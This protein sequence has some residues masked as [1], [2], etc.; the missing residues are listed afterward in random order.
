MALLKPPHRGGK[1]ASLRRKSKCPEQNGCSSSVVEDSFEGAY[2]GEFGQRKGPD[3]DG[4]DNDI[5]LESRDN[6]VRWYIFEMLPEPVV[7][8]NC[9][10]YASNAEEGEINDCYV[11][12]EAE[13]A[14]EPAVCVS[15]SAQ[16]TKPD[17]DYTRDSMLGLST[18]P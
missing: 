3:Q 11:V 15:G 8:A 9:H 1:D 13:A 18:D 7:R 6:V 4:T 12:V 5:V 17:D 2:K 14:T 10:E 16:D